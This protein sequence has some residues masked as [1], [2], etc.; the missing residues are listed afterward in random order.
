MSKGDP[1]VYPSEGSA[2]QLVKFRLVVFRPSPSE[3]LI[4]KVLS[5]SIEGLLVS[6]DF[7]DNIIIP[8]NLLQSP[9][10]FDPK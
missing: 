10:I 6:M 7:F 3:I 2:H 9:S 4:G 8:S 5:C 1:Y